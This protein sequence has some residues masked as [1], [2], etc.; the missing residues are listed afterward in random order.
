MQNN[1]KNLIIILVFVL[2]AVSIYLGI[3]HK[4]ILKYFKSANKQI[5]LHALTIVDIEK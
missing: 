1:L 4:S 5:E 3:V 2:T